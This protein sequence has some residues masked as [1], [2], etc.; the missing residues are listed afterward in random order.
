VRRGRGALRRGNQGSA[1]RLRFGIF[2]VRSWAAG[3]SDVAGFGGGMVSLK[4]HG[5]RVM[6]GG[7][8]LSARRQE[9]GALSCDRGGNQ[10]GLRRST[11][12]Y[13]AGRG[14]PQPRKEWASA[15]G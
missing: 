11:R 4:R 12:A 8:H 14:R 6:T 1:L 13:K 7:A 5:R 9:E 15:T 10:V 3:Q 2:K